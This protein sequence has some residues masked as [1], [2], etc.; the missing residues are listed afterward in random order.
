M[1]QES[2]GEEHAMKPDV[3]S[4]ACGNVRLATMVNF[5]E[6][7]ASGMGMLCKFI[8]GDIDYEDLAALV[9][10]FEAW[11]REIVEHLSRHGDASDVIEKDLI[12]ASRAAPRPTELGAV[13]QLQDHLEPLFKARLASVVLGLRDAWLASFSP[14]WKRIHPNGFFG[15]I[16]AQRKTPRNDLEKR[17]ATTI[18]QGFLQFSRFICA[19]EE[20]RLEVRKLGS[21]SEECLLR[22]EHFL[23]QPYDHFTEEFGVAGFDGSSKEIFERGKRGQDSINGGSDVD[24][25]G[26]CAK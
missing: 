17:I 20:L 14:L 2:M 26:P 4:G 16:E 24:H 23:I 21:V 5:I 13:I 25:G 22:V 11:Q 12:R 1:S 6:G 10:K 19:L 9:P 18:T 15:P 3:N 8:P 7:I